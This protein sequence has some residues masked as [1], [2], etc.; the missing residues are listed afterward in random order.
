MKVDLINPFIQ[1]VNDVFESMLQG[2]VEASPPGPPAEDD[3]QSRDIAGIISLS[4]TT[5]ITVAMRFPVKT[6]LAVVGAML[7][8]KIKTVDA[9]IIDAVGELV[10]ITAG[11]AKGR[12]T[13]EK[14]SLSLPTVV[15]GHVCKV[16]NIP[17]D[18]VWV[19]I[20]FTSSFGDFAIALNYKVLSFISP[21]AIEK[22][23]VHESADCR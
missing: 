3:G 6:V 5:T 4:G 23:V 19:E 9:S 8:D 20:P 11:G 12:M 14:L 2:T 13:G 18:T 10:N 15:R 1:S 16:H 17:K 21:V 22:E 7:G